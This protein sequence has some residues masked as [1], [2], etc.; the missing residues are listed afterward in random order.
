MALTAA[1]AMRKWRL[2]NPEKAKAAYTRSNQRRKEY[3]KT[4][5]A[6]RRGSYKEKSLLRYHGITLSKFDQMVEKQNYQCKI[7]KDDLRELPLKNV[8]VDHSHSSGKIRGILCNK[9]NQGLGLFKDEIDRL[10]AAI[11]YL[12]V[13]DG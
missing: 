10:R 12:E 1:E 11:T 8:H 9:C 5:Y 7:C 13:N 4:Y 2:E 3:Q 6:D